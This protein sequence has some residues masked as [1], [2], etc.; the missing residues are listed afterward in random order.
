MLSLEFQPSVET[1]FVKQ[2]GRDLE[3]GEWD[4]RYGHL[5]KRA[6]FEGSLKLIVSRAE[7]A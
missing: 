2:L 6:Q 1:R 4:A 5:R 3:S 7:A